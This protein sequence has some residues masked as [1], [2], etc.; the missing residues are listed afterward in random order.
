M[1]EPT[2]PEPIMPEPQISQPQI[3]EPWEPLPTEPTPEPPY[4]PQTELSDVSEPEVMILPDIIPESALEDYSDQPPSE[5]DSQ[6][7]LAE[8]SQESQG[9]EPQAP[10]PGISRQY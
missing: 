9:S 6:S 5:I 3:S 10:E 7:Q 4:A 1:P 2:M 8:P